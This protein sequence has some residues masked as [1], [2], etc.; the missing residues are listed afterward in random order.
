MMSPS[1]YFNSVKHGC[2][3]N[4]QNSSILML[5]NDGDVVIVTDDRP[6]D[7]KTTYIFM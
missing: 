3:I 6:L 7:Y 1:H 4:E 2:Y 5:L